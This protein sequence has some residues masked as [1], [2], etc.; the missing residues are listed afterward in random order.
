[1]AHTWAH[2]KKRCLSNIVSTIDIFGAGKQKSAYLTFQYITIDL[3]CYSVIIPYKTLLQSSVLIKFKNT[4]SKKM[5]TAH[6][7]AKRKRWKNIQTA[8]NLTWMTTPISI[9]LHFECDLVIF[10]RRQK[11]ISHEVTVVSGASTNF[12]GELTWEDGSRMTNTSGF[13]KW[14]QYCLFE[15]GAIAECS[16]V[17]LWHQWRQNQVGESYGNHSSIIFAITEH[18]FM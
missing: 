8:S 7:W 17:V 9:T 10:K 3:K 12:R 15:I 2:Q 6:T 4:V 16:S 14:S 11:V 5:Q 13:E 1:M 18:T